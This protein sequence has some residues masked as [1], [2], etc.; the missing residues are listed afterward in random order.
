MFAKFE[1]DLPSPGI[2]K[3]TA[4]HQLSILCAATAETM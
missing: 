3:D 4:L 1:I 2:Y